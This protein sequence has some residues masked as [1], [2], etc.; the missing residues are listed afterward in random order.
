MDNINANFDGLRSLMNN[1]NYERP[2]MNVP[3]FKDRK[4]LVLEKIEENTDDIYNSSKN[5]FWKNLLT[6]VI[7][8]AIGGIISYLLTLYK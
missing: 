4:T 8:G 7:G 5:Q 6:S 2:I 3:E 1:M